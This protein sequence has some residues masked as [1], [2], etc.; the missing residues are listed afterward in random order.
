MSNERI[1]WDELWLATCFLISQRSIDPSTKHACII[2][3]KNNRVVSIGYNSFPRDCVDEELPTYRPLKYKIVT[4]SEVNAII[5]AK[6][7]VEGCTA[8]I[9]GP[10]CSNCFSAMLNAGIK[11][12]IYGPISSHQLS[13][14]EDEELIRK[15]NVS[16]KTGFNK[17]EIVEIDKETIE[18]ALLQFGIVEKRI[19]GYLK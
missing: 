18:K 4:H 11:K 12:I 2:V 17:I 6:S 10:P 1:S 3:D 15:M 19:R 9:T 14:S 5:N 7:S 13:G 16:S 8:Y